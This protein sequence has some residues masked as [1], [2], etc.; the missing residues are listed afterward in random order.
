M[1]SVACRGPGLALAKKVTGPLRSRL[2]GE[3][4]TATGGAGTMDSGRSGTETGGA[5]DP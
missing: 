5:M 3:G 1:S 2:G 4:S